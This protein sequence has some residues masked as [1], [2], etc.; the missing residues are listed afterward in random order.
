LNLVTSRATQMAAMIDDYLRLSGLSHA[1]LAYAQ[2]D[3]TALVRSAW[4]AVIAGSSNPPALI[5]SELPPAYGDAGLLQQVWVNILSNAAKFTRESQSPTVQISGSEAN[6]IVRYRVEDNGVGFD[7]AYSTK[8]FRVFERLHNQSQ[9]EGNG[10]GLCVVQRILHRH[11]GDVTIEGRPGRGAVVEFW[12]PS[13][14]H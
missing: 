8:L 7:P 5:L 4:D 13:R 3:M 6:G 10:V 1:G 11:D 2:V 9:Y 14:R 12:L